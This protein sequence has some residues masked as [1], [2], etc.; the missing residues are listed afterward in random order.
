[1]DAAGVVDF[2]VDPVVR[3]LIFQDAMCAVLSGLDGGS[4][5]AP[6]SSVVA[7]VRGCEYGGGAAMEGQNALAK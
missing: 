4:E 1:M 2:P 7:L 6:E 3:L 5:V